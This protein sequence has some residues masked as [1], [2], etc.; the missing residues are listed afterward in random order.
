[1]KATLFPLGD[2]S[3]G[4]PQD[5]RNFTDELGVD[6]RSPGP[7]C[8]IDGGSSGTGVAGIHA[9]ELPVGRN[10]ADYLGIGNITGGETQYLQ[11]MGDFII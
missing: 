1:M 7:E 8:V 2:L 4:R 10:P 6:S 9:A 11:V 5:A 3:F